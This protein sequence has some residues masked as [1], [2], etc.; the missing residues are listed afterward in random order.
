M[1][2]DNHPDLRTVANMPRGAAGRGW[3]AMAD[4]PIEDAQDILDE[5]SDA[6]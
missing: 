2:P 4:I 6:Q 5:L 1:L 3:P